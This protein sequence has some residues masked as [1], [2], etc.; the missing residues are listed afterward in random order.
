MPRDG[1][2]QMIG[3]AQEFER[4][5]PL[6]LAHGDYAQIRVRAGDGRVRSQDFFEVGFGPIEFPVS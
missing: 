1:R 6:L 2:R 3:L 5:L 4:V